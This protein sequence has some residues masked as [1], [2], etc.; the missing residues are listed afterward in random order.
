MP[1]DDGS[2]RIQWRGTR[3][4]FEQ[5]VEPRVHVV[6]RTREPAARITDAPVAEIPCC[7]PAPR[8]I[9]RHGVQLLSPRGARRRGGA[10]DVLRH[11][12][13]VHARGDVAAWRFRSRAR[14]AS[15]RGAVFSSEERLLAFEPLEQQ[16]LLPLL[17]LTPQVG[18]SS[19]PRWSGNP[20]PKAHRVSL[21]AVCGIGWNCGRSPMSRW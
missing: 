14:L 6:Q 12:L 4:E 3:G 15:D 9:A 17:H 13:R 21:V 2:R 5:Y 11:Y 20:P 16:F 7:V 10:G 19:R 18:S 8:A 1:G